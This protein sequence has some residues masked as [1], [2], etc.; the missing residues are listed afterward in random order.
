MHLI[1]GIRH[2]LDSTITICTSGTL[3]QYPQAL[4]CSLCIPPP[5]ILRDARSRCDIPL[6]LLYSLM[7]RALMT[8]RRAGGVKSM[9]A[10]RGRKEGG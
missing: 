6:L 3:E 9:E 10:E 1:P 7:Y 4:A 8:L 2:L 5:E